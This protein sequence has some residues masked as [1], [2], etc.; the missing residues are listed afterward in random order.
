MQQ[1]EGEQQ[2]ADHDKQK[3]TGRKQYAAQPPCGHLDA[4]AC[5]AFLRSSRM[6]SLAFSPTM[7][8]AVTMKNP[9]IRGKTDA[10][11]TRSPF[12]PSTRK[13]LSRTAVGSLGSPILFE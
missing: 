10:S 4:P 13:R 1:N 9:G 12:V 8:T 11:T 3:S 5:S 2:G 7:Y 6:T